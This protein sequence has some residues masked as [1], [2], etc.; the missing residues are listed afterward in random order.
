MCFYL[1]LRLT[2][3]GVTARQSS[4][5]TLTYF[6]DKSEAEGHLKDSYRLLGDEGT[7]THS[8]FKS[9]SS[10]DGSFK[11][12][13]KFLRICLRRAENLAVSSAK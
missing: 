4:L 9:A 6:Q 8:L 13:E 7:I 10:D 11:T 2:Y 1:A 3:A 12:A 5:R